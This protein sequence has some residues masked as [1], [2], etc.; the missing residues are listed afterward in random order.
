M[1][2]KGTGENTPL[3]SLKTDTNVEVRKKEIH[4]KFEEHVPKNIKE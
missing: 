4:A 1:K 3:T 2:H